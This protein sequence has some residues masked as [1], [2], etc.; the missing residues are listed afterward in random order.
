MNDLELISR[1]NLLQSEFTKSES[2]I[3]EFILTNHEK[4][5]S[6][7]VSELAMNTYCTSS[8]V[9]KFVKKSGYTNFND[10]KAG[11]KNTI[12]KLPN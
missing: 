3:A 12:K 5:E 1:I 8:M 7:T 4:I 10:F 11:L 6:M 9:S 2:I